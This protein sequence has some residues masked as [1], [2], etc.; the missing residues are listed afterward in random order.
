MNDH[1][2][3]NR[4]DSRADVYAAGPYAGDWADYFCLDHIPFSYNVLDNLNKKGK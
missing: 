2:K 4:C 1:H 3:C